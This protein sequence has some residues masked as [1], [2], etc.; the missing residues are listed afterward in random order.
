MQ[1]LWSIIKFSETWD[2]SEALSF[3]F[4]QWLKKDL[5]NRNLSRHCYTPRLELVIGLLQAKQRRDSRAL[6]CRS[7]FFIKWCPNRPISQWR[8]VLRW[9]RTLDPNLRSKLSHR[10]KSELLFLW[11]WWNDLLKSHLDQGSL[12]GN[13][14]V[15]GSKMSGSNTVLQQYSILYSATDFF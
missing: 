14:L 7:D 1:S 3:P 6:R 8:S 11:G 2:S 15:L 9:C 4:D 12:A 5:K 10:E 13:E